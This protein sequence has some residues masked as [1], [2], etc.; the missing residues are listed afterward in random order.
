MHGIV[1]DYIVGLNGGSLLTSREGK[2][3]FHNL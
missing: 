2:I 3:L 1:Y